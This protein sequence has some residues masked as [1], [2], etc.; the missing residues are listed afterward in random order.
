MAK[1]AE[2]K[3]LRESIWKPREQSISEEGSGS[4]VSTAIKRS[5]S[6]FESFKFSEE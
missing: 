3:K 2:K 1:E 4:Q 5:N 6:K